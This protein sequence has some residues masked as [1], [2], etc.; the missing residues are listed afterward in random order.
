MSKTP[1]YIK[2]AVKKYNQKFERFTI[3]T[4]KGTKEAIKAHTTE[5]INAYIN[6]LIKEDIAKNRG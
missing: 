6:R 2:E 3:S 5:S 4:P 1:P